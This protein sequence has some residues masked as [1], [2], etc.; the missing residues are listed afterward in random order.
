MEI[1]VTARGVSCHG[2]A[3]E[4]GDNAVYKMMRLVGD[5]EALDGRLA[6]D[7][8]LGKGSCAVTHISCETPSLCAVPDGCRIHVDRRLTHGEDKDLAVRQ[9]RE[10]PSYDPEAMALEILRYDTP[11]Y[12]GKVLEVEK[13]FPTWVLPEDHPLVQAGVEA[14]TKVRGSRP[15]ISRWVFSTNGV[16]TTGL[17][18]TPPTIGFGP[19]REEYAHSTEDKVR[20]D[21]LVTSVAFYAALPSSI[22]ARR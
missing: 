9:I 14:A 1:A 15:K 20:I 22:L 3:P 10:L 12:T 4:R 21:D 7:P 11:S 6:T 17:R 8:F 5:I 2:S 19:A 18:G 13:Y 16:F